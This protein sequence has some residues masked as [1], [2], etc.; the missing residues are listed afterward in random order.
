MSC[1]TVL[2]KM[3]LVLFLLVGLVGALIHFIPW[4]LLKSWV[5]VHITLLLQDNIMYVLSQTNFSPFG[6]P[7]NTKQTTNILPNFRRYLLAAFQKSLVFSNLSQ[8]ITGPT[9]LTPGEGKKRCLVLVLH[10]TLFC[11]DI[12]RT[13]S[14]RDDFF[15]NPLNSC[16][17]SRPSYL[18]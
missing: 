17:T 2:G 11:I 16:V 18:E 6:F 15:D 13:L 1:Q 10:S 3:F 14:F 8:S 7:H 12:N 9:S 5:Y 4:L